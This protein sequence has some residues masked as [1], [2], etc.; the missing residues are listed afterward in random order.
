MRQFSLKNKQT[1]PEN[2]LNRFSTATDK[3]T[4]SKPVGE[5]ETGLSKNPT[6]GAANCNPEEAA[7]GVG[8]TSQTLSFSLRN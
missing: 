7:A 6:P 8:N 5:A 4:T 1:N 3:K 2:Q